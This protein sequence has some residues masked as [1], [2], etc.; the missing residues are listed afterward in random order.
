MLDDAIRE[1]NSY[2]SPMATATLVSQT[3]DRFTVRFTGPFSTT[4][5]RDDYFED[6]IY[7]LTEFGVDRSQL[8]VD[9]IH[10]EGLETF[11]ID[12]AIG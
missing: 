9:T 12:Y 3:T 5:C 8:T 10:H 11:V 6:L 4:C 7:E 2:R 1:Y